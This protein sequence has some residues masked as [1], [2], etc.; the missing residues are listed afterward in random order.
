MMGSWSIS[1]MKM[2]RSW[3]FLH[4]L[5]VPSCGLGKSVLLRR[6]VVAA[7]GLPRCFRSRSQPKKTAL[8]LPSPE[9]PFLPCPP[10]AQR[11]R[12]S[13]KG[14]WLSVWR[15]RPPLDHSGCWAR[16]MQPT[17]R[18]AGLLLRGLFGAPHLAEGQK[19]LEEVGPG[20]TR[21]KLMQ[22]GKEAFSHL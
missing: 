13:Q 8:A 14:A 4:P 22:A 6:V 10:R 16:L 15:F 21:G 19:G 3:S 20:G 7:R 5:W 1:T 11:K 12:K 9:K 18:A 2:W 17:T